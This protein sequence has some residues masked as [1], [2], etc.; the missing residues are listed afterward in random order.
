MVRRNNG[1]ELNPEDFLDV[2]EE[3]TPTPNILGL[4]G[5]VSAGE[6]EDEAG[7]GVSIVVAPTEEDGAEEQWVD[8]V[9]DEDAP[10]ALEEGPAD[11][12]IENE[13]VEWEAETESLEVLDDQVRMY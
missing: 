2:T 9:T 1:S 12:D 11:A 3:A 7:D 6:E 13:E 5:Q 8:A 10:E 4:L